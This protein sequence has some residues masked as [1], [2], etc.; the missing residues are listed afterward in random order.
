[1]Y[2]AL[3][4]IVFKVAFGG[5][6]PPNV[7]CFNAARELLIPLPLSLKAFVEFIVKDCSA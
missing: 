6:F 1:M 7:I 3:L 2:A 5:F 4:S